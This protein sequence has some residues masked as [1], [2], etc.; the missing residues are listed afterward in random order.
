M[1]NAARIGGRGPEIDG[2]FTVLD[3]ILMRGLDLS[4]SRALGLP[5]GMVCLYVA[6][7]PC[8]LLGGGQFRVKRM[9]EDTCCSWS[10]LVL[11]VLHGRR[12]ITITFY[13]AIKMNFC[14]GSGPHG[15]GFAGDI[16]R[17]VYTCW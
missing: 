10:W 4:I 6:Q 14:G 8:P 16:P 15:P 3:D 12:K 11:H 17:V 5:R 9:H 13:G 1:C 7:H 2:F